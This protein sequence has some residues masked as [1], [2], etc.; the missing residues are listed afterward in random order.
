[1]LNN[2]RKL[3]SRFVHGS[4]SVAL[5]IIDLD[6]DPEPVA[7]A[8]SLVVSRLLVL[9]KESLLDSVIACLKRQVT[10]GIA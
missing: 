9:A 1:M 10:E 8:D 4:V 7:E 2:F 3:A 5:P 6:P